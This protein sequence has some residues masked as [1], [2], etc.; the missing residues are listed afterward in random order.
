MIIF[1]RRCLYLTISL[2]KHY[3]GWLP[4]PRPPSPRAHTATMSSPST[5]S[6]LDVIPP[7][8]LFMVPL[9]TIIL[10]F[11]AIRHTVVQHRHEPV[12]IHIQLLD[13]REKRVVWVFPVVFSLALLTIVAGALLFFRG[14]SSSVSLA[15]ADCV[16][17][18]ILYV[19]LSVSALYLLSVVADLGTIHPA[20]FCCYSMVLAALLISATFL[21]IMGSF[22]SK[23]VPPLL[24]P[25][26]Y[27]STA[28]LTMPVITFSFLSTMEASLAP[29]TTLSSTCSYP[30]FSL[31]KPRSSMEMS[32]TTLPVNYATRNI[33]VYIICGQVSAVIHFAF[34][35]GL[36]V[37]LPDQSSPPS[38]VTS[39]EVATGLW[40]EALVFRIVQTAFLVSWII[41]TMSAFLQLFSR[42]NHN[43]SSAVR[44]S[45]LTTASDATAFTALPSRAM[46][47]Q[48]KSRSSSFSSPRPRRHPVIPRRPSPDDFQNLHDPFA[49]ARTSRTVAPLSPTG[50]SDAP[51]D[52]TRPT[53][54]SA[55]GSL[56]LVQEAPAIPPRPPPNVLVINPPARRLPS[57][58]DLAARVSSVPSS[59]DSGVYMGYTG[60]G[61]GGADSKSFFSYTTPSAYS[62]DGETA[63][64][65]DMAFDVEEAMLA[66]K[67]LRRLD[68]TG[69]G[70]GAW[71]SLKLK[72]NGSAA[73]GQRS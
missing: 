53:R 63:D 42:V 68:A 19:E 14:R 70:G 1:G 45:T 23:A 29:Q 56:P 5:A 31:E 52:G 46:H 16:V 33:P 38:T 69:T 55:W 65:F 24:A 60:G 2:E 3:I 51:N 10:F 32:Q 8:L 4:F 71:N 61:G 17:T 15:V 34:A 57:L 37:L 7:S 47:R 9:A 30:A 67:L 18:S 41:C 72:R 21:S 35:I 36:L 13:R 43:S 49:S 12:L 40:V 54:M 22:T 27:L 50:T 64:E 44:A 39:E 25:I 11:L 62:Q 66:Q 58:R 59:T 6:R 48:S 20:I 28:V 26:L 73:G